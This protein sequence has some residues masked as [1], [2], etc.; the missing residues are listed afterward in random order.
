MTKR[1]RRGYVRYLLL[2]GIVVLLALRPEVRA[3]KLVAPTW[4]GMEQIEPHVYV[5]RGMA[6]ADRAQVERYVAA[7]RQR[8]RQYYGDVQSTPTL[9]F[10]S[11]EKQFRALGGTSQRGYALGHYACVF[12]KGGTSISIIAHEGSHA[13]LSARLGFWTM[14]RVPQWFDEGLAVTVSEEPSHNES[15]YQRAMSTRVPMPELP[16]LYFFWQWNAAAHRY[17]DATINPE[18]LHVLYAA[19]G[20]EVRSW[21][22]AAGRDGLLDFFSRLQRGQDFA[23]ALS[24]ARTAARPQGQD[25]D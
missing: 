23:N 6:P 14:Q 9:C 24:D 13:E 8:L 16:K 22:T 17:G 15:V 7:A 21:Y 10:C 11:T 12:S 20:H 18:H 5:D 3:A 1:L 19:V 25:S 4:F 2:I